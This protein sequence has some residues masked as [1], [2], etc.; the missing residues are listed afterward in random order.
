MV[1]SEAE[2]GT[3]ANTGTDT[4]RRSTQRVTKR[5]KFTPTTTVNRTS[6]SSTIA[7][8]NR[9]EISTIAI[10]R[11]QPESLP[12]T[13]A[14]LS[15]SQRHSSEGPLDD[16]NLLQSI[17]SLVGKNQYFFIGSVNRKFRKAYTSLFRKKVTYPNASSIEILN[18][19]WKDIESHESYADQYE[20]TRIDLFDFMMWCN[21]YGED[22]LMS[23]RNALWDSAIQYGKMDVIHYFLDV[24][25]RT[26]AAQ[27][28]RISE[29]DGDDKSYSEEFYQKY[30]NGL[31]YKAAKYGHLEFLQWACNKNRGVNKNDYCVCEN[32]LG[33]G[34]MDIFH[35]AIK[36]GFA[37]DDKYFEGA[38]HLAAENGKVEVLQWL[39]DTEHDLSSCYDEIL[40]FGLCDSAAKHGQVEVLKWLQTTFNADDD[41]N[42]EEEVPWN[43][44]TIYRACRHGHVEAVRWMLDIGGTMDIKMCHFAAISG[45]V[46][47]L[48]LLRSYGCKWDELVPAYAAA[49]D[50]VELIEWA[51]NTGCPWSEYTS[52]HAAAYGELE[53]LMKWLRAK[54][55]P[56]D[57][58]TACYAKGNDIYDWAVAHGCPVAEG[59]PR[60]ELCS[61][62]DDDLEMLDLPPEYRDIEVV[63]CQRITMG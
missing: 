25:L 29:L 58:M 50:Q 49:H 7:T 16:E 54:G 56:W 35:W 63:K 26:P 36:N 40:D 5:L 32:A 1:K 22:H 55:C 44:Y 21:K 45:S 28:T 53:T 41:Q 62:L 61:S 2:S 15:Q 38:A 20:D 4:Q 8:E 42:E 6:A 10:T 19:C 51:V 30:M 60:Y 39:H 13:A 12:V 18:F 17:F 14:P 31:D 48:Q 3:K 9:T 27:K 37:W 43:E 23:R 52:H 59:G 47:L 57:E 11:T 46:P 34:H 24:L 33:H